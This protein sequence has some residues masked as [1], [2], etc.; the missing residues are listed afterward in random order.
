MISLRSS[1]QEELEQ[2]KQTALEGYPHLWQHILSEWRSPEPLDRAWLMYSANCLFRFGNVCWALDPLTLP[3]R[4]GLRHLPDLKTDLRGLDFIL[5]SHSHAD[6]F[7]RQ[8]IHSL[9]DLPIR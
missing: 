1:L 2:R 5:L 7:N 8:V 3:H 4:L 6:H 9:R